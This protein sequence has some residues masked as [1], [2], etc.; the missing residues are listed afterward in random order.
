MWC[1]SLLLS[2]IACRTF[3]S[4]VFAFI[5]ISFA[6]RDSINRHTRLSSTSTS[7]GATTEKA[8]GNKKLG[9]ITFD[10]DDTLYPVSPVVDEANIAFANAMN[11]FGYVEIE[12]NDI[13]I[14]CKEIRA[15]LAA[16]DQTKAASMT[17]TELNLLSIRREMEKIMVNR[18]L[19]AT[20]DGISTQTSMLSPIVVESAK[21][22]AATAVSPSIISAVQSAWEM[23][24]HHAAERH[25]YP[26]VVDALK[27]IKENNPGVIIGAVTDGS[28]NPM[29][30]TFT[31]APLFDFCMSWEDDQG[32]RTNFFKDLGNV[33]G[34]ADLA[35]IYNAAKE[36]GKELYSAAAE[37]NTAAAGGGLSEGEEETIW[38]HVGD[39][40]AYDVGGS[41]ACGAKPILLE[42]ADKYEQTARKRFEEGAEQ[43]AWSSNLKGELEKIRV[44]NEAAKDQ[45]CAK[46]TFLTQ[47]PDAVNKIV[48]NA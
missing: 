8:K 19:K 25:L 9:L 44:M 21:K 20:A 39:N 1:Q 32:A 28:A 29:F 14:A 16:E 38:I 30:M 12:A 48:K 33:D 23:E 10:L 40:L 31:L 46:V 5:P 4:T 24:R 35:W 13:A 37:I 2:F 7:S 42:L 27:E 6:V 47:L 11:R 22:W 45:V 43:P 34:N 41:A 15:E 17:R 3:D 18:K 26:E 36:K